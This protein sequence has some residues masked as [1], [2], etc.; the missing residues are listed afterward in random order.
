MTIREVAQQKARNSINLATLIR[1]KRAELSLFE[2]RLREL[3]A[4][5]IKFVTENKEELPEIY[6]NLETQK[7]GDV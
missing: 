2:D 7:R 4:D 6:E 1:K 3:D 5:F